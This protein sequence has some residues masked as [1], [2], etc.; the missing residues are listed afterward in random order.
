MG[1]SRHS[2]VRI[3]VEGTALDRLNELS[4]QFRLSRTQLVTVLMETVTDQQVIEALLEH[5]QE[6]KGEKVNHCR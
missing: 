1:K 2:S 6:D 5:P 4:S 3:R